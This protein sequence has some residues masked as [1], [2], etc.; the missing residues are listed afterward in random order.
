MPLQK[1]G[2]L[3]QDELLALWL[4]VVDPGYSTP[5]LAN[6]DSGL[7][8]VTQGHAQFARASQMVDR[9]F[10]AM[11]ILPYSGQTGDP[12]GGAAFSTVDLQVSRSN[13]G[14]IGSGLPIVLQAGLFY[15]HAPLD[16]SD[17]GPVQVLTGR[18]YVGALAVIGPGEVGPVTVT[19][20]AE[21]AT[22]GYDL[23]LPGTITLIDQP[24]S[25]FA[26]DEASVVPTPMTN[27]LVLAPFPDVLTPA[28]IGQY[29]QF[30]AG[31]NAGR[32]RRMIG[33]EAS[34]GT[35]GGVAVLAATAVLRVAGIV[36][37]FVVG[38]AVTQ[39]TSGARAKFLHSTGAAFVLEALS[40]TLDGT[41]GLTG[42]QSGATASVISVD[43]PAALVAETGT[44]SWRVL[45]WE[46]DLGLAVTNP[47]SPS[48]GRAPVLDEIGAERLIF[49]SPGEP[50]D[51]YRERVAAPADKVSPN[52]LQRAA[53]RVLLP[54]GFSGCLREVGQAKFPGLF[55][56]G[57][58]TSSNPAIAFAFDLDFTT[59]PAD[60]F[61][62]LLDY[63]E[64][65]AFFLMGVP[66][67]DLGDFGA[68]FDA[69]PRGF[70]DVP[71]SF[72]IAADGFAVG[73]ANV[74]RAVWNALE[75]RNGATAGGV[76]FDL[77]V[78]DQSCA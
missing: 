71:A 3:T 15:D 32:A 67:L 39:A 27:R 14:T 70:F 35:N 54:L 21:R 66:P 69:H 12:A 72:G 28:Q 17:D 43:E 46:L 23:P 60:R 8:L 42:E 44:A 2:P 13:P 41:H 61:K 48:G 65:R 24:G 7:E 10:Q 64:F 30:T 25:T 77:Y 1:T 34:G 16:Y 78:E 53:N 9:W 47:A 55:F 49:R 20:T 37:T 36:G 4:S 68:A 18:R 57:D 40:G 6:P 74:Y 31:A 76:G 73:A 52:A 19:A 11:F 29:V 58:P 63:T 59:R 22:G 26:N 5:L 51:Q 33:Y 75:P 62:L 45:D 50:D 56:D 38:E